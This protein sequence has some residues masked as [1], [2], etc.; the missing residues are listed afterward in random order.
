L[1]VGV[2]LGGKSVAVLA[3][4]TLDLSGGGELL[5]AGFVSGRGGST[6]AR[7][8]PLVQFGA[9]GGFVLPG[10]STNPVY[11]IVPGVQP[12][13]APA[14]GEGGAVAPLIGQQITIGAGVPGLPAGTYTLMP[15]TYALLPGAF[16]VEINGLAGVGGGATQLMRNGSWSTAG[17]L[18]IANTGIRDSLASQL[19]LTSA[20]TL[21]RYSQYNETSYAQFARADAAKL[22]VPR[23]MLEV[24]AKT[25]KLAM[26]AGGGASAFTFEGMGRFDAAAGGYGG[27]VAVVDLARGGI[28]VVAADQAATQGFRGITFSADSLNA[29][30]A[31][32]LIIGGLPYV[33][34]G[35]SGS[36]ITFA[37][38]VNGARSNIV[39][40]EGAVLAAPEV[41]LVSQTGSIVVE[42]G[43]SINTIGRGSAGFD[44]RDGFIYK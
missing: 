8:N 22:G 11:A 15:S 31:S 43:A 17:H 14:G 3:D 28:E 38:G 5:G 33:A 44:A 23:A 26:R 32:R 30:G 36:Y 9:N 16:R 19:I 35:Q 42:Q 4:A 34:Y 20:D 37:E 24:D 6:D 10:L 40:R 39:L 2:I 18:S 13:A 41:L 25:L 27:T 12:V 7:F 1:A 21:R 29:L